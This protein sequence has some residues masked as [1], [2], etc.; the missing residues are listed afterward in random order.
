MVKI[1]FFDYLFHQQPYLILF[2]MCNMPTKQ[3]QSPN[4]C[5]KHVK[6]SG[7]H[8][9]SQAASPSI[10]NA[11]YNRKRPTIKAIK[12][13]ESQRTTFDEERAELQNQINEILYLEDVNNNIFVS[14]TGDDTN[15][16]DSEYKPAGNIDE[17]KYEKKYILRCIDIVL[18]VQSN[19]KAESMLTSN[20]QKLIPLFMFMNITTV[21]N[22][23]FCI[24]KFEHSNTENLTKYDFKLWSRFGNGKDLSMQSKQKT[25]V[26]TIS[27]ENNDSDECL[28][29]PTL[30]NIASPF[31]EQSVASLKAKYARRNEQLK[32]RYKIEQAKIN[33]QQAKQKSSNAKN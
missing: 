15:D 14:N 22:F 19:K 33:E 3:H 21:Y 10:K 26:E 31:E 28:C 24:G 9:G 16:S 4:G 32:Q 18:N 2:F 1:V 17:F 7:N 13:L 27:Y 30:S 5:I 20:Q 23:G 25:Q 11:K 12:Q 8:H 29:L 6:S